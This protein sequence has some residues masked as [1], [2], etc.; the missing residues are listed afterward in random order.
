MTKTK[1]SENVVMNDNCQSPQVVAQCY[2]ADANHGVERRW[3]K[4]WLH[5]NIFRA[6]ESSGN[7][8]FFFHLAQEQKA[9]DLNRFIAWLMEAE[10]N[11]RVIP[12]R[13]LWLP[14][15]EAC[16]SFSLK[17]LLF[18][19]GSRPGR[20]RAWR[21]LKKGSSPPECLLAES[22][23]LR[24]LKARFDGDNINELAAFITRQAGLALDLAEHK[25]SNGGFKL[26]RYVGASIANSRQFN[27]AVGSLAQEI[28][29][30]SE[31]LKEEAK[32]YLK[33]LISV[34]NRFALDLRVWL[35]N[36]LLSQG[37]E[38]NIVYNP[39][40]IEKLKNVVREHPTMVLWTHKI[41]YDGSVVTTVLHN[42]RFPLLHMFGG[43]NMAFLGLGYILRHSGAIF[44]RRSFQ[45]NP[46]YKLV[47][48]HYIA[49]LMEKRFPLSWAFEGTRSRIGKL[50]PPRYGLLKYVLES[51]YEAGIDH[52]HIIPVSISYDFMR[53]VQ[54]FA[55]EQTG[56]PKKPESLKWFLGYVSS[57][58]RPM[59]RIYMDIADPVIIET[60][61]KPGDR[62]ALA[63]AAFEVAVRVNEV[64]PITLTS[65]I[66]FCL[67]GAAPR[68]LTQGELQYQIES[69]ATWA[70][71]RGIHASSDF[72]PENAE[73]TQ[74]LVNILVKNGLLIR[75]DQGADTVF[76]IEP[77]EHPVASYYRN[78]IVHHFLY[79]AIL[80]LALLKVS[81]QKVEPELVLKFFWEETE[82][83]RD[84][85]KFEFFYPSKEK[86]KDILTEEMNVLD[87]EWMS[88]IS[89]PGGAKGLLNQMTPIVAHAVFLPFV[90]AYTVLT[91]LVAR[92]PTEEL[93]VESACVSQAIKQAKQAYLQRRITSEAS[94]AKLLFSN[95]FK[96]MDNLGL[97]ATGSQEV[98][99]RRI[100][101][102]KRFRDKARS[103]DS[104]R[105]MALPKH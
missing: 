84:L 42:H 91:D 97:L 29:K 2:I 96:L 95:A 82:T 48:R 18:G 9:L 87:P 30:P 85:F 67:L 44:I 73:H 24:E 59:G 43:I 68:A 37:Y 79:K 90:E 21:I 69:L 11:A 103:L 89:Q 47:L 25:R 28:G 100:E 81:D 32:I 70:K 75:Y 50:M 71:Q 3:L 40:A 80:E 39:G 62:L 1:T 88:L 45:D 41:Y 15:K 99:E 26:P 105:I 31:C 64:T 56:N 14:T 16:S 72:D 17:Q 8:L 52:I 49:Y 101:L 51:A 12:V 54:D 94:I 76:G 7:S 5:E 93:A 35:D 98:I 61:P 104:L 19:N 77:E 22:A 10:D 63:K 6:Q 34:P 102:S 92:L 66:C 53:D 36:F 55:S 23:T 33:E 13:L 20:F 46:L 27:E 38:K 86:F 78:M 60:P 4:N 74:E 58:R 83:L 57:L 65:L